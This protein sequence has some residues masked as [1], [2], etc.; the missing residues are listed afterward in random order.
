MVGQA[1]AQNQPTLN[2]SGI[3]VSLEMWQGG[4]K[5]SVVSVLGNVAL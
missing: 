1:V 4:L 2:G 3:E 5:P